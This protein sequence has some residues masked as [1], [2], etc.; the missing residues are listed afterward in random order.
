M[1]GFSRNED[2][3]QPYYCTAYGNWIIG[4]E[5]VKFPLS[6]ILNVV[7]VNFFLMVKY[8]KTQPDSL[9]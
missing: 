6:K 8:R 2:K 1:T 7:R 5:A 9:L 3:H 4:G